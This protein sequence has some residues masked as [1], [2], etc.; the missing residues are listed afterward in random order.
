[1][2]GASGRGLVLKILPHADDV[3]MVGEALAG[4]CGERLGAAYR[5]MGEGLG[6]HGSHER[7][8]ALYRDADPM[9]RIHTPRV[10]A[11]HADPNNR[12][13]AVLIEDLGG[14]RL[15]DSVDDPGAWTPDALSAAIDGIAVVHGAWHARVDELRTRNWMAPMRTTASMEAM[16]PLW[17]ALADHA[18]PMFAAWAGASVPHRQRALID[19][20]ADWRPALDAAPQTLIH[21]DFNPRNICLKPAEDGP[22][23][24]KRSTGPREGGM[25]PVRVSTGNWPPSA[26]RCAT[27]RSSSASSRR[28][29]SSAH[30]IEESIERHAGRFAAGSGVR[31]DRAAW[32][33]AFASALAEI[34]IDRLSVYA[35]VHRV[36]PQRFLPRVLRT[37]SLLHS[38]FPIHGIAG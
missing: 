14:A 18:A 11:T 26:R 22:V 15:L 12:A 7:E 16:A 27:W 6:I 34:L 4:I 5:E 3:R 13:W 33:A 30:A 20:I 35:M 2:R 23:P 28:T 31:I 36:R 38:L 25:A 29:A 8:V 19:G 10:I 37:W 21:N 1:M 9:L 24:P 32:H 17:R